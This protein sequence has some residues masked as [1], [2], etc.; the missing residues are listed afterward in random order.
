MEQAGCNV[1]MACVSE[2]GD[3]LPVNVVHSPLHNVL[4]HF[5]ERRNG[6]VDMVLH[7]TEELVLFGIWAPQPC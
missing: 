1:A 6:K 7:T 2:W 4:V 5:V 3:G